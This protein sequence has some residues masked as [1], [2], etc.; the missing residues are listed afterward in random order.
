M[1]AHSAKCRFL[2]GELRR[3]IT[4]AHRVDC[5]QVQAQVVVMPSMETE[6]AKVARAPLSDVRKRNI[7]IQISIRPR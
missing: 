3:I 2:D 1:A 7:L 4:G 6:Q 5:N